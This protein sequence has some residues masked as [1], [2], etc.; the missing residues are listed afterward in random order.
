MHFGEILLTAR[1]ILLALVSCFAIGLPTVVLGVSFCKTRPNAKD[2]WFYAPLV[3]AGVIILVCQNLIY[4]DVVVSQSAILIWALAAAAWLWVLLSSSRRSLLHP[5]P[6]PALGLGAAVYLLHA[7]GLLSLGASNYYGYGWGDMFNYV[8]MA[9]FFADFTFHSSPSDQGFLSAAHYYKYDRIGQSVLHSFLMFSS[10]SDAQQSFGSTIF[11]SPFLMFFGFLTIARRFVLPSAVSHLAALAGALSPTVATIHLECFFSQSMCMPFLLLWPAAVGDLVDRSGWRSALLA[12]LLASVISAIYTELLPIILAIAIAG[13]LAKDLSSLKIFRARFPEKLLAGDGSRYPFVTTLFWL[14]L[15]AIVGALS[16]L[17]YFHSALGIFSRTTTGIVLPSLYPWAFKFEGLARLWLG[18]QVLLQP[19]WIVSVL[20]VVTTLIFISIVLSL[21]SS[22]KRSL[23][24]FFL[25]LVLLM[26][27]P[28]GPLLIGKGVQYPYQFYKLL[29]T[30]SSIHAFWFV[31]GLAIV[32]S[33]SIVRQNIAYVFASLLIVVNGFLTFS[34]TG[35]SAK[36]STVATSHRGGAN[37][38]VDSDFQ[39]LRNFL[40]ET[41]DRDVLVLWYDN[42]LYSGAYR[43]AWINYFA[44][45]NRVWSLIRT[46]SGQVDESAASIDERFSKQ[47]LQQVSSAIV[48]TWK[49][50]D[51]L[52]DRL[53][54]GNPLL[55]VYQVDSQEEIRHLIDEA[56]IMVFRKLRLDATSDTAPARWYPVWVAGA[57]GSATLLTTKFGEFNEFRYD[58]WGSPAL[59]LAPQGECRGKVMSLTVQLMLIDKRLRMICN[60]AEVEAQLPLAYSS[61]PSRGL[62]RF[63]ASNGITSLEGKYPLEENFPG[64]VVEMP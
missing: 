32:T 9:Q 12:G 17:G 1:V 57:P 47:N 34:I 20:V 28:L 22:A 16:N 56:R 30:V 45:H 46:S 26:F 53:L 19:K 10:G 13:S 39:R 52:K 63:G 23:S 61:F 64:S 38:L 15:T 31:V 43:T 21:V 25:A 62:A 8:S 6:W 37:L 59:Y 14:P 41:R 55:S 36:V 7:S 11:L 60:G 40:G 5:V 44:R 51:A 50:L 29:L 49:P 48:V 54:I 24:V 27:I 4:V 2:L 58:Q 33:H 18:N 42:E 35:A 3:G